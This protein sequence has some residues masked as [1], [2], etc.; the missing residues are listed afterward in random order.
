MLPQGRLRTDHADSEGSEVALPARNQHPLSFYASLSLRHEKGRDRWDAITR[1]QVV[2]K[3]R[4]G[5]T[6]LATVGPG[7]AEV[8]WGLWQLEFQLEAL[9]ELVKPI[10]FLSGFEQPLAIAE[11][12][13]GGSLAEAHFGNGLMTVSEAG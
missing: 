5:A 7:P 10:E 13:P 12:S 9:S 2:E 4:A 1:G 6:K 8:I 3:A 11:A